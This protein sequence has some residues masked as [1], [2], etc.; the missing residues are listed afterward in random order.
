MCS[1]LIQ[2]ILPATAFLI[3]RALGSSL[4]F[5]YFILFIPVIGAVSMLPISIGGLGLRENLTV[6]LFAHAGMD[7]HMALS[8]SLLNFFFLALYSG[9]GG[10]IYVLG[11]RYRRI[12][13]H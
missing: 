9:I 8:M 6:L 10:V 13:R 1:I 3:A 11:V 5:N 7:Q 12:Q 2:F 4:N